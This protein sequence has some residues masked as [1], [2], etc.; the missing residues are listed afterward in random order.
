MLEVIINRYEVNCTKKN[1]SYTEYNAE[2][3]TNLNVCPKNG[4]TLSWLFCLIADKEK[5]P[6]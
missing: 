2:K 4:V 1:R 3:K 5:L 6:D